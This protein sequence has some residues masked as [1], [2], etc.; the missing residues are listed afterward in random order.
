MPSTKTRLPAGGWMVLSVFVF[1]IASAQSNWQRTYGGPGD[2]QGLSVQQTADG[3]YIIAGYAESFGAG[4]ADVYLIKTD[5]QGRT[6]WTRAYGG[7]GK[8]EGYSVQQTTDGGY[9]ILGTTGSF[10]AGNS[11]VCLIGEKRKRG[12]LPLFL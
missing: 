1:T 10:G 12:T 7:P 4:D 9:A 6:L 5:A 11:D 2:D 3:G 8:D